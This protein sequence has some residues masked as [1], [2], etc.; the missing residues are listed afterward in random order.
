[1]ANRWERLVQ[2]IRQGYEKATGRSASR[3]SDEFTHEVLEE[4]AKGRDAKQAGVK[5]T[6]AAEHLFKIY[7][8]AVGHPE[9]EEGMT[10]DEAVTFMVGT[11]LDHAQS[12]L[13]RAVMIREKEESIDQYCNLFDKNYKTGVDGLAGQ[14]AATYHALEEN[15]ANL[16]RGEYAGL[17]KSFGYA[18]S[19]Q[20][21]NVLTYTKE[22]FQ[23][24]SQ[25]F[26][27]YAGQANAF[28]T[29]AGRIMKTDAQVNELRELV[30]QYALQQTL[31][32]RDM[33]DFI[34]LGDTSAITEQQRAMANSKYMQLFDKYEHIEQMTGQGL[35][36]LKQKSIEAYSHIINP[37][38]VEAPAQ[39]AIAVL[40]QDHKEGK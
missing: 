23:Q 30:S 27:D 20:L 36:D 8:R 15:S 7:S 24:G 26:A 32:T 33:L 14:I 13:S 31:A 37:P 38:A 4:L 35:D 10:L 9:P 39:E 25:S 3:D 21:S 28:F 18:L 19:G 22:L 6:G 17:M 12:S 5:V 1:M 34:S 40:V 29:S 2:D 16:T 11:G